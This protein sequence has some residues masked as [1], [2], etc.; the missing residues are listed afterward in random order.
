M[1]RDGHRRWLPGALVLMV[2]A[3]V[4]ARAA[5]LLRTDLWF[6]ELYSLQ[7]AS[8]DLAGVWA[9]ALADRVHPPGFYTIVWGWLAVV[10]PTPLGLRLLPFLTWLG[11]LAAVAWLGHR[12]RLGRAAVALLVLLAAVNPVLFEFGAFVRGYALLIALLTIALTAAA[13]RL[14]SPPD[15]APLPLAVLVVPLVLA[16]WIH[17]FAW[18]VIGAI[19]IALL[20]ARRPRD[21]TAVLVVP[22]ILILPWAVALAGGSRDVAG[23]LAAFVTTPGL[24]DLLRAPGTLLLGGS[25]MVIGTVAVAVIGWESLVQPRTVRVLLAASVVCTLGAGWLLSVL[26]PFGAWGMRYLSPAI[27]PLLAAMVL[28]RRASATTRALLLALVAIGGVL[29]IRHPEQAPTPWR[30]AIRTMMAAAPGDS[31]TAYASEGFTILPLRY[32]ALMMGAP[33]RVPEVRGLPAPDAPAG[34]VVIRPA[35]LP[36]G[37][38]PTDQFRAMGRVVTDSFAVGEGQMAVRGW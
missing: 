4:V 25:A 26:T 27:V 21:A 15:A 3:V 6:D 1:I 34:W 38:Q 16:A 24:L 20:V 2:A 30:E 8:G 12:L 29:G 14:E 22:A 9:A 37:Y 36:P 31:V 5:T 23:A 10:D 11:M 17:Y 32:H 35:A 33:L 19:A 28:S 7:A 13:S 18:P